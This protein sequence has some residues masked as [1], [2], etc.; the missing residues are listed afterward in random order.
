MCPIAWQM[1]NAMLK[2]SDDPSIA[3]FFGILGDKKRQLQHLL[4]LD[5]LRFTLDALRA[6]PLSSPFRLAR[7]RRKF[8]VW[9]HPS[10]GMLLV[11]DQ[12]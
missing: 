7:S 3:G 10:C 12:M 11:L 6:S 8:L 9:Q 5:T 2:V 4:F 1:R